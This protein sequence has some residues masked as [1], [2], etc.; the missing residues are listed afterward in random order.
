MS[1]SAKKWLCGLDLR[2]SSQG[3]IRWARWL[4]QRTGADSLAG[5][6]VLEEAHLQAALRYH[7]LQELTDT[8]REVAGDVLTRCGATSVM[9]TVDIVQ[10]V[11]AE[12]ALEAARD[13]LGADVIVV[14]RQA[15]REGRHV[16]R[17]GRVARRLLRT[18][19]S[20][21]VVVPP[22]YEPSDT[23]GPVLV[24]SNLR[25]DTEE[26]VR[27]AVDMASRLRVPLVVVHV[28]PHAEDYGA[29]YIPEASR[30]KIAEEH[31]TQGEAELKAW[32]HRVGVVA[33]EALVRQGGIVESLVH[34]AETRGASLVVTG[35]RLLSALERVL[36]TSTASEL[37][38]TA[39]CPVA[40]VP[41]RVVDT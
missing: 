6:H 19:D 18:L 39:P 34:V 21:V 5:V 36:L 33:G 41:P 17:L 12:E 14:G 15:P 37:A 29:Y 4:A 30:K 1:V 32:L 9:S 20:P 16:L 25:E 38:A 11:H 24:G 27:F 3:A 13:R 23:P 35:S 2:P 28:V 31:Q 8:A 40:V 7:H 26:A 10:G 22:D